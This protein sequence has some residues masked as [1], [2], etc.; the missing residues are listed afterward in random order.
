[1]RKIDGVRRATGRNRDEWFALLDAWG[2]AGRQYREIAS[3][4]MGEHDVSRWWARNI[5]GGAAGRDP[6]QFAGQYLSWLEDAERSVRH[7]FTSPV[8]W[9]QFHT[10]RHEEIRRIDTRTA[11]PVPLISMETEAQAER[12]AAIVDRLR[13]EQ[14]AFEMPTGHVAV[15][16]DTNVFIHY[17]SGTTRLIGPQRSDPKLYDC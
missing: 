11:R 8:M 10:S 2:A 3:W 1:M 15:L 12:L 9:Q 16:P 6:R 17:P 5:V 4:L 14:E 13:R 7:L